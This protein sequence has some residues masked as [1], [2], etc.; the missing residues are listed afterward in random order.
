MITMQDLAG[1]RTSPPKLCQRESSMDLQRESFDPSACASTSAEF[2]VPEIIAQLGPQ[3]IH[4]LTVFHGE[5][6][7]PEPAF[8]MSG[9]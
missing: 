6:E 8:E 3:R 7:V 4:L 1:T 2:S 5:R 9:S